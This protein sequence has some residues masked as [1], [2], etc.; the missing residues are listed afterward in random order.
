MIVT[1][2]ATLSLPPAYRV[3]TAADA[4]VLGVA[5]AT[6]IPGASSVPASAAS[7]QISNGIRTRFMMHANNGASGRDT[8]RLSFPNS[9]G[10]AIRNIVAVT[11][12]QV[13]HWISE[14]GSKG[15]AN[16]KP[17]VSIPSNEIKNHCL[18]ISFIRESLPVR[19]VKVTIRTVGNPA[20]NRT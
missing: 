14:T 11:I 2:T 17:N 4:K 20:A 5:A 16:Q 9:N 13:S 19:M 3:R 1:M 10:H 6:I 7:G 18:R 12:D 15:R 8:V